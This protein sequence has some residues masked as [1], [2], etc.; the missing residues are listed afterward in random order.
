MP[1]WVKLL[2]EQDS[3]NLFNLRTNLR[4]GCVILRHYVDIEQGNLFRALGRYNGSLGKAKYPNK[5]RRAWN[6]NWQYAIEEPKLTR[7]SK[8][9][10]LNKTSHKKY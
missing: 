1:F 4:Y 9:A 5:V 6:R 8:K 2:G 3:H 7:I 10:S